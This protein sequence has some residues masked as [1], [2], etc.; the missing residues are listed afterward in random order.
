MR[1]IGSDRVGGVGGAPLVEQLSAVERHLGAEDFVTA[2]DS[3][4][5]RPVK[6][7]VGLAELATVAEEAGDDN[8]RLDHAGGEVLV[9][10]VLL[11]CKPRLLVGQGLV[12]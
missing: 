2:H 5:A 10:G 8:A 12:G 9:P 11:G 7:H 1:E 6:E 3:K 4:D